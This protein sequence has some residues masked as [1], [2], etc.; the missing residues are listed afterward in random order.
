MSS[1]F[2]DEVEAYNKAKQPFM[3][4]LMATLAKQEQAKRTAGADKSIIKQGIED[5]KL[6]HAETEKPVTRD[7]EY[8]K[9]KSLE[10]L[11]IET[12]KFPRMDSKDLQ[13]ASVIAHMRAAMRELSETGK[14]RTNISNE[15]DDIDTLLGFKDDKE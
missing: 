4:F 2:K 1:T 6:T 7:S 3:D 9:T 15:W 11:A 5:D 13:P 12:P 10:L 8:P 14:S